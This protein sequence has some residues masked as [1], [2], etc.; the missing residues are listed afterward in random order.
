MSDN[1]IH[2]TPEPVLDDRHYNPDERE[3]AFFKSQ[4][5]IEDEEDLKRHIL[6]VQVAAYAIFPYRCIYRLLF[7][8]RVSMASFKISSL[9]PLR[10]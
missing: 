4:T 5:G 1:S 2:L 9:N 7:T 6:A 3:L 8:K 10:V